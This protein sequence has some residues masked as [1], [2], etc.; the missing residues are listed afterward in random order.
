[1]SKSIHIVQSRV[2]PINIVNI[3]TEAAAIRTP[4]GRSYK[5]HFLILQK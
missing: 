1:M 5:T 3:D 2:V 4:R